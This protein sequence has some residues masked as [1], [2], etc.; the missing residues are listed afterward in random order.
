MWV[1]LQETIGHAAWDANALEGN[2][3]AN[4]YG[5][6]TDK[7]WIYYN[8]EY[9]YMSKD[10]EDKLLSAYAYYTE[11]CGIEVDRVGSD[12]STA[13]DFN[14]AWRQYSNNMTN[15]WHG[16]MLDTKAKPPV[17][18]I[19]FYKRSQFSDNDSVMLVGNGQFDKS[20]NNNEIN[21]FLKNF[22][23]KTIEI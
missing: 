2:E 22:R 6:Q 8:A 11:E 15:M 1:F 17:G 4:R 19:L 9:Y 5:C 16:A 7:D 12:F 10:L 23:L 3:I 14:G 13:Y 21:L 20:E 18:F